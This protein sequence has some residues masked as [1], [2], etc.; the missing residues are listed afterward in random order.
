MPNNL[1][2]PR[3][4]TEEILQNAQGV[5]PQSRV[6]KIL[7]AKLNGGTI[8]FEPQS[9]VEELLTQL[10]QHHSVQK[11]CAKVEKEV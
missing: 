10:P 6:E 7:D 8:D 3:S 2:E 9:R 1:N 11:W 5:V 4:R